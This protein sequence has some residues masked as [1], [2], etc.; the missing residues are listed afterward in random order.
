MENPL[1]NLKE[2]SILEEL[3]KSKEGKD[4]AERMLSLSDELE[5]L[6]DSEKLKFTKEFGNK[7]IETLSGLPGEREVESFNF[8]VYTAIISV[9]AVFSLFGKFLLSSSLFLML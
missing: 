2:S 1:K 6:P 8:E 4:I 7:F 5:T 3:M 9:I